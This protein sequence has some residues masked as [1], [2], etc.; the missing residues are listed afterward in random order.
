MRKIHLGWWVR[1]LKLETLSDLK[2]SLP[3]VE[4]ALQDLNK[5]GKTQANYAECLTSFCHWL[6]KRDY[7]DENPLRHLGEFDTTP[8]ET[9]RALTPAEI[10]RLLAV[11]PEERRLLYVVAFATGLR[12]GEIRSLRVSDLN[13]DFKALSLRAGHT[14]NRQAGWQRLPGWL[15]EQLRERSAGKAPDAPLLFVPTHTARAMDLDLKKAGI[16]KRTVE[17]KIDFHASRNAFITFLIEAQANPKE[18]MEL[19][20]HSTPGL[21]FN[22]YARTRNARL[23]EIVEKVGNQIDPRLNHAEPDSKPVLTLVPDRKG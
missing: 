5:A 2:G 4:A 13:L 17:G 20:R 1:T 19:A 15:F 9:R 18:A 12:A 10:G 8:E 16:P 3:R 11:A 7:L 22:V 6:V 23:E 21:T 14:K